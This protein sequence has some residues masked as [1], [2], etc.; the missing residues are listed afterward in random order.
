MGLWD[1]I[2]GF[3]GGGGSSYEPTYVNPEI[4][5][6]VARTAEFLAPMV[7]ANRAD[8]A[9]SVPIVESVPAP[10]YKIPGVDSFL[11]P[12][13]P[14]EVSIRNPEPVSLVEKYVVDPVRRFV[15]DNVYVIQSRN[16]VKQRFDENPFAARMV[17]SDTR[18]LP[19]VVNLARADLPM[20]LLGTGR[21][22]ADTITAGFLLSGQGEAA[23][24]SAAVSLAAARG[25]D[26]LI[27]QSLQ[28]AMEGTA[29]YTA[30]RR[31][32]NETDKA[33]IRIEEKRMLAGDVYDFV[34]DSANDIV[35]TSRQ[36]LPKL[37]QFTGLALG[38]TEAYSGYSRSEMLGDL[39]NANLGEHKYNSKLGRAAAAGG[40]IL[41]L[42]IGG[43]AEM[44]KQKWDLP[45]AV[46]GSLLSN[47]VEA[48]NRWR[49]NQRWEAAMQEI[50]RRNPNAV[51]P[52]DRLWPWR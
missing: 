26:A 33:R 6:A 12:Y 35:L 11:E 51:I 30:I 1:Y 14:Y 19:V 43:F 34:S 46:G 22:V 3:F 31:L 45:G 41:P 4:G 39:A 10:T 42:A 16:L 23:P 8:T 40:G 36:T 25:Q 18:A 44:V 15:D 32:R 50:G 52:A 24:I 17:Y 5:A 28:R 2:T 27:D 38:G 7:T 48:R 49:D 47:A 20:G 37:W 29:D 21:Q 13:D 9:S